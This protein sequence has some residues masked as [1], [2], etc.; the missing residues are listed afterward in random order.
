MPMAQAAASDNDA[1]PPTQALEE[2]TPATGSIGEWLVKVYRDAEV[3]PYSYNWKGE[4]KHSKKVEALLIGQN[5]E[6]YCIG[7]A[8]RPTNDR[9][10]NTLKELAK[11]FKGGTTW[12]MSAVRLMTE[13][14]AHLGCSVKVVV[15]LANTTF[16]PVLQSAVPMPVAPAPVEMLS[17]ILA[18]KAT[19]RCDVTCLLQSVNTDPKTATTQLG[20]RKVVEVS[21]CDG[22]RDGEAASK[23]SFVMWFPVSDAGE[24]Q[25][26]LL[27]D[28][29]KNK[30]PVSMFGLY[31]TA[32]PQHQEA[33]VSC[34]TSK[35]FWWMPC[36]DAQS[37]GKVTK[38]RT[39]ASELLAL[40]MK[41]LA[42]ADDWTPQEKADYTACNATRVNV[43]LLQTIVQRESA[44]LPRAEEGGFVIFQLNCVRLLEPAPADALTTK[45]GSRLFV[46]VRVM[47]DW[48]QMTL[49]MREAAALQA[50]GLDSKNA[51]EEAVRQ[52]GLTF[53]VLSSIRVR[54]KRGATVTT[55]N[56]Q[57]EPIIDA[58]IVEAEQ[59][60]VDEHCRPNASL[61]H[62][63]E[64]S[65]PLGGASACMLVGRLSQVTKAP[66]AGLSVD[67]MCCDFA[68]V[69]CAV[70]ARSDLQKLKQGY[71]VVTNGL[72]EVTTTTTN[73]QSQLKETPVQG[74]FVSMC[75]VQN[76]V[77][78]NLTPSNPKSGTYCLA[79]ISNIIKTGDEVT[80]IVDRVSSALQADDRLPH[81]LLLEE[82]AKLA[83]LA[84]PDE[85]PKRSASWA[86][87]TA[88]ALTSAKKTRALSREPTNT[89][90]PAMQI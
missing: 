51:F 32:E 21:V 18:V 68:L 80:Y 69:L 65:K 2:L 41:E 12:K 39:E 83:K 82:M 75:T 44:A 24:Q 61:M 58:I 6:A 84:K 8:R 71:R 9:D 59:Q 81:A 27:V 26:K 4:T 14:K 25:F 42:A 1:A 76:S 88:S 52:G 7:R 5:A 19:Q 22:S 29:F 17:D 86:V 57:D 38:L 60:A 64:A 28:S 79:V 40:G 3:I 35:E 50:S 30:K 89:P 55:D 63:T 48:G 72:H 13:A 10:D 20:Q 43:Q 11:K 47:D 70:K 23:L 56:S 67:G 78:F 45:D 74:K 37:T 16:A 66:H 34:R 73:E 33:R 53:P 85:R 36:P 87:E 15:D 90:L 54:V 77:H 62:I 49:R 31:V 46:P